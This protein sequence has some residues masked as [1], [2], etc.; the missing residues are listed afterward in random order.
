MEFSGK[1]GAAF[2]TQ[3]Q[4]R[5]SGNAADSIRK[6]LEKLGYKMIAPPLVA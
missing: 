5:F 2:D 3:L 4:S 1:I 6:K